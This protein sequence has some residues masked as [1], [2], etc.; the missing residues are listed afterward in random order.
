[1]RKDN[2]AAQGYLAKAKDINVD[3][4]TSYLDKSWIRDVVKYAE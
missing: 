4:V 2:T 1:L 3:K